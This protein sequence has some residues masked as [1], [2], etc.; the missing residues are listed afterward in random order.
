M[1]ISQFIHAFSSCWIL[2]FCLVRAGNDELCCSGN[3]PSEESLCEHFSWTMRYAFVGQILFF[4]SVLFTASEH[5]SW[6]C[7]EDKQLPL[8]SKMWMDGDR[9]EIRDFQVKVRFGRQVCLFAL[10]VCSSG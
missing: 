10:P 4:S 1:T 7:Q 9:C 6:G 3:Y 5:G 2:G 8:G